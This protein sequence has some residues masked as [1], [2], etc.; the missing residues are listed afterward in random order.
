[1]GALWKTGK[2]PRILREPS[3]KPGSAPGSFWGGDNLSLGAGDGPSPPRGS[4]RRK[5]AD[6]RRRL[7]FAWKRGEGIRGY[8][9]GLA[10][11]GGSASRGASPNRWRNGQRADPGSNGYPPPADRGLMYNLSFYYISSHSDPQTG[12]KVMVIFFFPGSPGSLSAAPGGA[13]R[14]K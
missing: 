8:W 2:R 5:C 10:A 7:P 6:C 13:L 9:A 1:M 12:K 11:A 14:A 3:G 4:G